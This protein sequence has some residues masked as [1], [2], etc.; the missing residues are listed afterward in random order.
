[1]G[2]GTMVGEPWGIIPTYGA[3][4]GWESG[5]EDDEDDLHGSI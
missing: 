5:G 1:M 4:P 2:T 3:E